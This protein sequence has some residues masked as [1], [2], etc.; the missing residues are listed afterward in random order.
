MDK[1]LIIKLI[2]R[3]VKNEMVRLK[4]EVPL[5]CEMVPSLILKGIDGTKTLGSMRGL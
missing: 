4:R 3:G 1:N 5:F 2:A